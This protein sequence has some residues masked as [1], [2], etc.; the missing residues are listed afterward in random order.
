MAK[1]K[2]NFQSLGKVITEDVIGFTELE[3]KAFAFDLF[4]E[5][6]KFTPVK[7]G[8]A[9]GNWHIDVDRPD[10]EITDNTI[11]SRPNYGLDVRG[12]PNVYISNGLPYMAKLESGSSTQAPHGIT[13]VALAA[14]RSR[15]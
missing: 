2:I 3:Y 11:P 9:R 14:V 7:S 8:R 10:Y 4:G 15:R 12:F 5:I 6:I 13:S 1:K